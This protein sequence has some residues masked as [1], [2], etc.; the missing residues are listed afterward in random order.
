MAQMSTFGLLAILPDSCCA[1]PCSRPGGGYVEESLGRREHAEADG[2]G[3]GIALLH[4]GA[5]YRTHGGERVRP[6]HEAPQA[7][8]KVSARHIAGE[9]RTALTKP[10][11]L[12]CG[13]TVLP[14]VEPSVDHSVDLSAEPCVEPSVEPSGVSGKHERWGSLGRTVALSEGT[15]CMRRLWSVELASGC[16]PQHL[17]E[18][19]LEA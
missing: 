3:Q 8:R 19:A 5:G 7:Q 17:T 6:A 2:R 9:G 13:C 16:L 4:G 10:T 1:G 15:E 11:A 12:P 18:T 14:F